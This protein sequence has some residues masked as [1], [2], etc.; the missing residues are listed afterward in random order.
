MFQCIGL[1][2]LSLLYLFLDRV[3]FV[4]G[5]KAI[6]INLTSR[7][8]LFFLLLFVCNAELE[9]ECLPFLVLFFF[10][11]EIVCEMFFDAKESK[12]KSGRESA[13]WAITFTY[14][15]FQNEKKKQSKKK[16]FEEIYRRI[17][18]RV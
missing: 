18:T 2:F 10:A 4:F 13:L 11:E 1:V 16:W 17:L 12:K 9:C 8:F 14:E 7:F 15:N 5:F 6:S 3:D